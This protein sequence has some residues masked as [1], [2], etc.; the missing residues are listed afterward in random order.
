[1]LTQSSATRVA[2][3]HMHSDKGILVVVA[4]NVLN[5]VTCHRLSPASTA[6]LIQLN[7]LTI[8]QDRTRAPEC[9]ALQAS[10]SLIYFSLG[11]WAVTRTSASCTSS[12]ENGLGGWN[13]EAD[14]D[15][16]FPVL[17]AV[18]R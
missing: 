6:P 17:V 9:S 13:G 8:E 16:T 10:R 11:T 18:Q 7:R 14:G 5:H 1:M 15:V 4:L 2:P 12:L 3:V